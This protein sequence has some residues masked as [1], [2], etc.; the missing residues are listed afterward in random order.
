MTKLDD[1][2]SICACCLSKCTSNT[3]NDVKIRELYTSIKV[4][5]LAIY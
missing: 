4:S 1:L 2:D 3:L 5:K